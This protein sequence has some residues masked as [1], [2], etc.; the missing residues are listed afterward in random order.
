VRQAAFEP[1]LERRR[2]AAARVVERRPDDEV[3]V[4]HAVED[5]PAMGISG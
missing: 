2:L 4:G 5:E 3:V 1:R